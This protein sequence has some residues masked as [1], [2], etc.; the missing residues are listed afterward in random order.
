MAVH[1]QLAQAERRPAHDL[2]RNQSNS[3][4]HARLG[5]QQPSSPGNGC[6][7]GPDHA[8]R[9]LPVM[10]R[11]PSTAMASWPIIRASRLVPVGSQF[12]WEA[13]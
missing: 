3:G 7:G 1:Y 10:V 13:L 9:V 11:T 2:A 6:E 5:G 12:P 4:E 8:R